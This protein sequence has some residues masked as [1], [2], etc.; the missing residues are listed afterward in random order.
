MQI[1]VRRKKVFAPRWLLCMNKDRYFHPGEGLRRRGCF[2]IWGWRR[3]SQVSTS[4]LRTWIFPFTR[5]YLLLLCYRIF[6]GIEW[7]NG[8]T[9]QIFNQFW[10]DPFVETGNRTIPKFRFFFLPSN[11]QCMKSVT[12]RKLDFFPQ[13]STNKNHEFQ[14]D[15]SQSNASFSRKENSNWGARNIWKYWGMWFLHTRRYERNC[16][17]TKGSLYSNLSTTLSTQWTDRYVQQI[18]NP[19]CFSPSYVSF[20]IMVQ[21]AD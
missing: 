11:A 12:R 8:R 2:R 18:Q 3:H 20:Q 7:R 14:W 6:G 5:S 16:E 10:K 1:T 21:I 17:G 13:Y 9:M 19:F 15:Y 4:H